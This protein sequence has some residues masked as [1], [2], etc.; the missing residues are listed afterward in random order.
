[1]GELLPAFSPFLPPDMRRAVDSGERTRTALVNLRLNTWNEPKDAKQLLLH[2]GT[3]VQAGEV[4]ETHTAS[5]RRI[6]EKAWTD[7]VQGGLGTPFH[8]A[9][10][11]AALVV[12]T[13]DLLTTVSPSA[14][15]V[16]Y[17]Q[18]GQDQ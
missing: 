2:L 11:G 14:K 16:L 4:E 3:L 17:V 10:A 7:L 5:F 13:G 8:G 15:A 12:T 1:T 6:Y 18:G 9:P